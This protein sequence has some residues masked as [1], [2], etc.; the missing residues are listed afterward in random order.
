[1]RVRTYLAFLILG[2]SICGLTVF[3]MMNYFHRGESQLADRVSRSKLTLR[4]VRSLERNFSH[5]MLLS[6]LVLG[7]DESYLCD[8]AVKLGDEVDSI[9]QTL[10]SQIDST[11][12]A[13]LI[14]LQA[15]SRRQKR[16]LLQSRN[17]NTS[18]RQTKMNELL[19]QM[20]SDSEKAIGSLEDLDSEIQAVFELNKSKLNKRLSDQP[21][22]IRILLLGFLGSAMLLWLWI[23]S[24]VSHPISMLANQ[25]R[26]KHGSAR[27]FEVKATAPDEV[28][29]LAGCLGELVDDLEFQIEE[30]KKTQVERSKLHN[31]LMISSRRAGMADV[32]SEVLHNVGNVLNSINVSATV[33]R[34]SLQKSLTP[35]LAIANQQLS[36]H[37][38]DLGN[39]LESDE[40]G[41]HFP[42]ALDFITETL[43][44]DRKM[45]LEETERLIKN[46]SHMR[47]VIQR[48]L[49][50]SCDNGVIETFCLL[51]LIQDCLAINE[52]KA[53]R[54]NA[55]VNLECPATLNLTT[56][57]HQLQQV[58]INLI[59]NALDAVGGYTQDAG[60]VRVVANLE[61]ENVVIAV[62]DNGI[63]IPE[64][65]LVKIFSQGFTTKQKGHGFGLHSCSLIAQALGGNLNVTSK[66]RGHGTI[67]KLAI[68]LRQSELCKI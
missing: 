31:K 64:E 49:S 68:P 14:D 6:D 7:S 5:W 21:G 43:V 10:A 44:A 30:H 47:N 1:M 15:F 57:R 16:R 13:N 37:A 42:A 67:F 32:A 23:S 4:D 56:D 26:I 12:Q 53:N 46:I 22:N 25:T 60:E 65:N 2:Y 34:S 11:R 55:V 58:L 41:K 36:E 45:H 8:G 52:D 51:E 38:S 61:F 19:S 40:K 29:Q 17:L 18:D 66:G 59:S 63:G 9:L 54:F 35:K 27:N 62:V 28:K 48:Q 20:D 39:Y 24:I 3:Y 33:V 50:L